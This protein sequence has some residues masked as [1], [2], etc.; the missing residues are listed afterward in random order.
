VVALDAMDFDDERTPDYS[1]E[2]RVVIARVAGV[3]NPW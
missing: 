1:N 3:T 2:A